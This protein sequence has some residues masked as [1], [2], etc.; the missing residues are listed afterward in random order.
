[1]QTDQSAGTLSPGDAMIC[2]MSRVRISTTVDGER[3]ARCRALV[4]GTDSQLLDRALALLLEAQEQERERRALE[5]LPY[6]D[7]P[8]V[9]WSAPLGPDL[10][11]LGDVPDEVQRLAEERRRSTRR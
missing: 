8:D 10:A 5:H 11:Y 6:D 2:G 4:D 9:S 1:M 7:D 3:L